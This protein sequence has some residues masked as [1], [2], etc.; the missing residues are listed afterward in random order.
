ML[1]TGLLKDG[2]AYSLRYI[3]VASPA[4]TATSSAIAEVK[5]VAVS[6]GRTPNFFSTN[7]TVH[8]VPVKNSTK[9]TWEKKK[10]DS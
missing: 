1:F 8:S 5:A 10:V 4:G 6:K 7:R 2:R 9:E 3:A